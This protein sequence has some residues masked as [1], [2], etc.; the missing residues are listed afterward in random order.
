MQLLPKYYVD[1]GKTVFHFY[2]LKR[3]L[4]I[5]G[6][7]ELNYEDLLNLIQSGERFVIF[8]YTIFVLFAY[9]KGI[10]PIYL[11]NEKLK[12]K[13]AM[14]RYTLLSLAFLIPALFC[15][16]LFF[17][18]FRGSL[19]LTTGFGWVLLGI[20]IVICVC[21]AVPMPA[22]VKNF[23]GGVDVTD[24]VLQY[25]KNQIGENK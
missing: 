16:F 17:V 11:T 20:L 13:F 14:V 22:I 10:S 2:N 6:I 4:R 7:D 12:T 15:L 1:Y 23:R 8:R 5:V 9:T 3:K 18:I 19:S 21:I 24:D 25:I